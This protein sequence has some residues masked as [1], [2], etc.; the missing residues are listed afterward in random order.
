[1]M[2]MEKA[3]EMFERNIGNLK[4]SESHKKSPYKTLVGLGV[5]MEAGIPKLTGIKVRANVWQ[6]E[7][8]IGTERA[9]L[10]INNEA[11]EK[12]FHVEAKDGEYKLAR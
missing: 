3:I 8:W 6:H 5:Q 11:G 7:N 4:N 10:Y 9:N 2:T 1:M 12:I